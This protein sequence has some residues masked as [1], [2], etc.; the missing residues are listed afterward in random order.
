VRVCVRKFGSN[1]FEYLHDVASSEI[2]R[3]CLKASGVTLKSAKRCE[4]NKYYDAN[5]IRDGTSR[6]STAD[7]I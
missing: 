3:N 6:G 2:S 4:I 5:E 7:L 1:E